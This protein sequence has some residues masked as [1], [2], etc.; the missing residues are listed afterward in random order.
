MKRNVGNG[1]SKQLFVTTHSPFFVNSLGPDDVWVLEK[2]RDGYSKIK[3]ASDYA[4]VE[5]LAEEG[6]AVGDMWYSKYFENMED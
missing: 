2:D 6:V 5:E 1:F 3:R 4:F